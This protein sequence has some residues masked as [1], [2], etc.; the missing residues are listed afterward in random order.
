M[1]TKAPIICIHNDA[2]L[3]VNKF[4]TIN[5][6]NDEK[7]QWRIL[8]LYK[9]VYLVRISDVALKYK[10]RFHIYLWEYELHIYA[11]KN[12]NSFTEKVYPRKKHDYI[13]QFVLEINH[14]LVSTK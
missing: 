3:I 7:W 4:R 13:E 2:I 5:C 9:S 6:S 12:V 14:S 8:P 1:I 10:I 11:T